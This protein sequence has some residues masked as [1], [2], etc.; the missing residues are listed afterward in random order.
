MTQILTAASKASI[1]ASTPAKYMCCLFKHTAFCCN[2]FCKTSN[3][4]YQY[5]FQC[6]LCGSNVGIHMYVCV[7]FCRSVQLFYCRRPC[8]SSFKGCASSSAVPQYAFQFW[9]LSVSTGCNSMFLYPCKLCVSLHA[10]LF[11]STDDGPLL[12]DLSCISLT[13]GRSKYFF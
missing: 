8:S 7:F 13:G 5:F 6:W 10:V 4:S 2:F 11:A 1:C 3:V 12:I 9:L